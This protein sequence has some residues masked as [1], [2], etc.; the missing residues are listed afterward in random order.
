MKKRMYDF[1]ELLFCLTKSVFLYFEKRYNC[2]AIQIHVNFYVKN[3]Q[4]AKRSCNKLLSLNGHQ[5]QT[6]NLLK[7]I[8]ANQYKPLF[9][10]LTK[11]FQFLN[12]KLSYTSTA[13]QIAHPFYITDDSFWVV[14]VSNR[15]MLRNNTAKNNALF[16]LVLAETTI[17]RGQSL[18][19][20]LQLKLPELNISISVVFFF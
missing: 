18:Q 17:K 7:I 12:K 20:F 8:F 10:Y 16:S 11:K 13:I 9:L 15:G 5:Q 2:T 1:G 19:L 14:N 6:F 3:C 4:L